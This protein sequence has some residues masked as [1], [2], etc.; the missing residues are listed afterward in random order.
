MK[1]IKVIALILSTFMLASNTLKA[2]D[3]SCSLNIKNFINETYRSTDVFRIRDVRNPWDLMT[4]FSFE[5]TALKTHVRFAKLQDY[6]LERGNRYGISLRNLTKGS[7]HWM[8]MDIM[9]DNSNG[10]TRS[11]HIFQVSKN[12]VRLVAVYFDDTYNPPIFRCL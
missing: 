7:K 9:G 5:R 6:G 3:Q 2:D 1:T 4:L 11:L 10:L 8:V 12:S